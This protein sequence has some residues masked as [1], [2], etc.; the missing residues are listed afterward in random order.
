MPFTTVD[1]M[2]LK[3]QPLTMTSALYE[4][5]FPITCDLSIRFNSIIHVFLQ[6]ICVMLS[7]EITLGLLACGWLELHTLWP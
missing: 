3:L 2:F 5:Y 6:V 4:T 7:Q 1:I